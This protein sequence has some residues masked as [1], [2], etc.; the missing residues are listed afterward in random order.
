MV[1]DILILNGLRSPAFAFGRK[2]IC[3]LMSCQ[4]WRTARKR[5]NKFKIPILRISGKPAVSRKLVSDIGYEA[6]VLAKSF[7][8]VR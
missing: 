1:D 6:S 8:I 5:C 3:A 4:D 7:E 2:E